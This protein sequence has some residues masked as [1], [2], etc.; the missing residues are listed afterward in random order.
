MRWYPTDIWYSR[1]GSMG[2]LNREKTLRALVRLLRNF[3]NCASKRASVSS[4]TSSPSTS[5][6]ERSTPYIPHTATN[7]APNSSPCTSATVHLRSMAGT[8]EGHGTCSMKTNPQRLKHS[9]TTNAMVTRRFRL[10]NQSHIGKAAASVVAALEPCPPRAELARLLPDSDRDSGAT[11]PE[12]TDPLLV[13]SMEG[14]RSR[15]ES[16]SCEASATHPWPTRAAS[17]SALA[18]GVGK[19]VEEESR[20]GRRDAPRKVADPMREVEPHMAEPVL[21]KR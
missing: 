9:Y 18:W 3:L 17:I 11:R 13:T 15:S 12:P 14:L 16:T 8:V 6:Q 7:V 20:N 4:G 5:M 19:E 2:H 10:K 1:V 21:V